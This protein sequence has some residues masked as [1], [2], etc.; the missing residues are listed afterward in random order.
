MK[1]KKVAIAL[2]R[3]PESGGEYQYAMIL[4]E[5]LKR[6]SEAHYELI[7]ICEEHWRTWCETND[8]RCIV[9]KWPEGTIPQMERNLRFPLY[10]RIYNAYKTELGK[11]IRQEK[12]DILFL[13]QQL[14]YVPNLKVKIITPVHDLMHRYESSFAEVRGSYEAREILFK[15]QARYADYILVDSQL[16]KKQFEESYLCKK[17]FPGLKETVKKHI[18]GIN[19]KYVD[20]NEKGRLYSAF[21]D[22]IKG[23]RI[24]KRCLVEYADYF[25]IDT[26]LCRRKPHLISIPFIVPEH[27][28]D[29]QEEFVEVPDKYVFYPAQFWSH[30]NHINLVKAIHIL[31]TTIKDIQLVLVGSKIDCYEKIEKYIQDNDLEENITILGFVSNENMTYLYRQAA[32]LIMPTYFGPTNMPPLEAMA[33]G[34]PVAVSNKYAMPEQ[35]GEAGLLFNPDSP[36]EIAGCIRKL[37]TDTRLREKMIEM[38]YQRMKEWTREDFGNEIFKVVEACL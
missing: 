22:V 31:K 35:V 33:L 3:T 27:I 7:A 4:A 21:L 38:G 10:S 15:C 8:T 32:G 23:I 36:D 29:I 37:W 30:K 2:F 18:S 16:G 20:I 5:C 14:M 12:I 17:S 34:C 28:T 19:Q 13:T 11:I 6:F 1:R 9:M 24:T 26:K 25:L